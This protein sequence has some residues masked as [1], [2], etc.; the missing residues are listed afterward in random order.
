MNITVT[1]I[2]KKSPNK[3]QIAYSTAYGN[4]VSIFIGPQPKKGQAYDVEF[5]INDNLLWRDNIVISKK[6]A[7]SIHHENGKTLITAELI[8][9]EDD[10]CG[11]LKIGD[12]VSLVSIE[13]QHRPLPLFV[14]IISED[15]SF[16]PIDL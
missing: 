11:V 13:K 2:I 1:E 5:D 16:Y 9:I 4:G 10:G 14:D 7:P 6:R 12:S 3:T 8:A 15:I